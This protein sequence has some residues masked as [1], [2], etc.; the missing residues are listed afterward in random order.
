MYKLRRGINMKTYEI[1]VD[2]TIK[3]VDG[4]NDYDVAENNFTYEILDRR[5]SR[6]CNDTFDVVAYLEGTTESAKFT[7]EADQDIFQN[8]LDD[9]IWNH[10]VTEF[11]VEV[12]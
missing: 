12:K 11:V 7:V 1:W 8:E 5:A 4:L 6:G 9:I 3:T 2:S 10:I